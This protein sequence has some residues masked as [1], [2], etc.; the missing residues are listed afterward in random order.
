MEEKISSKI[1]EIR[2]KQGITLKELSEKTQLSVSFLSQV[3]R[4]VCSLTITSLK[5]I[6]DALG[7]QMR[8]LIDVEES[9][10]FV[11]HR[12]RQIINLE[13]SYVSYR[14]LSGKF[15]NRKLESVLLTMQPNYYDQEMA[16]HEGEE[17]YYIMGG[18]ATFV[19]DGEEYEV[20]EGEVIHFPSTL[21]HRTINKEDQELKMLC[22]TTPTIF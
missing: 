19:I 14:R 13:K 17:F 8:D 1:R 22:V 2:K 7:V 4:G 10:S 20:G 3:E 18:T 21:P 6:A 9:V 5:K 11:N 15:E 16:V 12:N